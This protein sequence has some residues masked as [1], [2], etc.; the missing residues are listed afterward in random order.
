MKSI[1][2][3]LV[4]ITV[5]AAIG[6]IFYG[7]YLGL[8]YLWQVY[9]GLDE[10]IRIV[11]LSAM[12]IVLLSALVIAGAIKS[13][14]HASSNDRLFESKL[15]LYQAVVESCAPLLKAPDHSLSQACADAESGL[16]SIDAEMRI[17]ASS[18]V[19]EA[20]VRLVAGLRDRSGRES[21]RQL[22]EKLIKDV[23]RDLGHAQGYDESRI[24]F[25]FDLGGAE[26][27]TRA[28][29]NVED[30]PGGTTHPGT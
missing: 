17:L 30:R 13:A 3:L 27:G 9:I 14:G 5:I 25:L 7:G 18:P 22:I 8:V 29:D 21:L 26:A 28:S 24:R 23:R 11:L 4:V 6:A 1:I 16:A 15:R 12:G 19:L 2:T 20:Y 10:V